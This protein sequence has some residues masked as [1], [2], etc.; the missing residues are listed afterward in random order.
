MDVTVFGMMTTAWQGN[1]VT[2]GLIDGCN[3]EGTLLGALEETK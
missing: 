2:V 3:T 1:D